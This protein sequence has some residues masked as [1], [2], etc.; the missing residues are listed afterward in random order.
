[1]RHYLGITRLGG[2]DTIVAERS[3][4]DSILF[5]RLWRERFGLESEDEFFDTLHGHL[6]K[7]EAQNE[8]WRIWVRCPTDLV[9]DRLGRRGELFEEVHSDEVLGRLEALYEEHYSKVRA[10]V[11]IDT[12]NL[13]PSD[14]ALTD[15][16]EHIATELLDRWSLS[17]AP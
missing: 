17:R 3:L 4:D 1:M 14:A 7:I 9:R 5:H 8:F 13:T 6:A 2:A 15:L 16:A 12:R 10:A 11:E